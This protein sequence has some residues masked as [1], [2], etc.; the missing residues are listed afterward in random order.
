MATIV[1]GSLLAGVR[2]SAHPFNA[3][4]IGEDFVPKTFNCT[5]DVDAEGV[6]FVEFSGSW[7]GAYNATVELVEYKDGE[8]LAVTDSNLF[9]GVDSRIQYGTNVLGLMGTG[10]NSK[11]IQNVVFTLKPVELNREFGI[12]IKWAPNGPPVLLAKWTAIE[13]YKCG[14]PS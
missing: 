12:R 14:V 13:K 9:A 5:G 6:R 3:P 1:S 7:Q 11:Y 8:E 2:A 10:G 4:Q